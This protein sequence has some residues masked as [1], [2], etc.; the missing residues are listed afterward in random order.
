MKDYTLNKE[1][2]KT[3]IKNIEKVKSTSGVS[4]YKITY[5]DGRVF[6]N[7]ACNEENLKKIIDTQEKQAQEGIKNIQVYE[8]K[9]KGFKYLTL[10]G[11]IIGTTASIIDG[12]ATSSMM[13][14]IITSVGYICMGSGLISFINFLEEKGKIA[15]LKKISYRDKNQGDLENFKSYNN[16]LA[17]INRTKRKL[18]EHQKDPFSIININNYSQDDLETIISN[19]EREKKYNFEYNGKVKKMK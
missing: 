8:K 2:K 9:A 12:N 18:L 11:V 6:K 1:D 19:I 10:A 17:G 14:T 3:Y 4:S 13:G 15:E 7:I 16:S 5:A